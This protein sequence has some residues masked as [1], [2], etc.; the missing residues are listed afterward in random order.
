MPGKNRI[1]TSFG[2]GFVSGDEPLFNEIELIGKAIAEKGW[3]VCSG[4]YYGTMEAI[5]KGAKSAGGK[6]IGVTVKDWTAKPNQYIDEEVKMRSLM[7][8]IVELVGVADAYIIFKGGTGTLV[9]ISVA[10]ELMNKKIMGEKPLIFYT[11]FWYNMIEI[12]KQDSDQLKEM[13]EKNVK[14]IE[15]S[16]EL[17]PL[18]F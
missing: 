3:I 6:T 17:T 13:I 1:I 9:E 15:N 16:N 18:L 12:L 14:F 5:S 4:G 10:L 8:R 2:S 7:E 11:N